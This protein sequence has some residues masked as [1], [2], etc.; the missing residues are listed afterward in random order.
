MFIPQ[1]IEL[2]IK[3]NKNVYYVYLIHTVIR[4]RNIISAFI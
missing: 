3:S 1:W 2:N 4:Q